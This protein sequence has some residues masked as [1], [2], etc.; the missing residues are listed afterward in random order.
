VDAQTLVLPPAIFENLVAHA[1]EG[2]PQEVCGLIRGR[3]GLAKGLV[4]A[5]NVAQNP[6]LNYEVD[7]EALAT[8]FDWEEAGDDLIAIYHSHPAG[9]AYPSGSDAYQA[10][11]PETVFLICSLS[12]EDTPELRGFLLRE[13]SSKIDL[14]AVRS[15]LVFDETRPDRWA[16]YLPENLPCPSS[17]A[18]LNRP[19]DQALYV[20]YQHQQPGKTLVRA[21]TV[22]EIDVVIG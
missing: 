8:L 14:E 11:Y 16:A 5:K 1:R 12:D 15:E 10:H 3:N 20:V 17:L 21:V 2:K 6:V 9:P 22:R 13:L 19:I 7:P 4:R 18:L